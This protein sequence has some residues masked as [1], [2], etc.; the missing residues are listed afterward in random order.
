MLQ[1]KL[2][3]AVELKVDLMFD[4]VRYTE[5]LARAA[6]HSFPNYFP[7]RVAPGEYDPTGTGRVG[8][9][10]MLVTPDGMHCRI[11]INAA[12]PWSVT[13][14]RVEGYRLG[15]AD[16]R[17]VPV[18]F[19]PAQR[20]M[21]GLTRDGIPRAHA[22]VTQHGDM[23]IVNVAPGCEYFVAPKADGI[24]MRCTFCTYGAPDERT[25]HLGQVM[26][27]TAIP[28]PTSL[29]LQ[30]VL[31]AVL[32][33]TEIATIYL[34]GGSLTDPREEGDR[35]VELAR[36]VQAVNRGRVP[37]TCGSGALPEESLRALWDDRLVDAICFNLEVW[38]EPL[39]ARVCPGKNRYVG[40][41]RWIESLERAVS[42]WGRERVY[43][44]M[45]AGVELGPDVGLEPGEATELALRGAEDLCARGVMPIYSPYWPAAHKNLAEDYSGLR[46]FFEDLQLGYHRIRRGHGLRFW[47]GFVTRRSAYMQLER[48]LDHAFASEEGSGEPAFR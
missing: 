43:S 15:H 25:K 2:P 16:G 48:D 27:R 7:H 5:A 4:G 14:A 36:S 21:A 20:W 32:E 37:V 29:R 1:R 47:D 44:A 18:D 40:Y 45:V 19:E 34:V 28:A 46:R 6:D 30:E 22:G 35:F 41:H 3:P 13:G 17:A 26:G 8:I 39:F 12:S 11:K 9:P 42:L 33:Q 23:I 38:S 10:Y 24:S 31:D